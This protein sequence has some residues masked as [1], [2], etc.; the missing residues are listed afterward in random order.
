MGAGSGES[1]QR[2]TDRDLSM[3]VVVG[4]AL[5]LVVLLAAFP[6]VGLGLHPV[7]LVGALL[8]VMF[9]FLFVTVSS[10]LTG[11]IGS[12]SNP[13]SGMTVATLL[14]TCLI[15]LLIGQTDRP[16]MLLALTIA[17]VVCVASSN[18]GT[19]A[20]DLKTGYLVGATPKL[21]QYGILIGAFTSAL[22]LGATLYVL[23]QAGTHY[24][25]LPAHLPQYRIPDVSQL[26]QL[27]RPGRPHEDDEQ[28]Y[29]VLY[30]TEGQYPGVAP[31]KYLVDDTGTFRYVVDPAINGRFRYLD[32]DAER[33]A[34]ETTDEGRQT[35]MKSATV[36]P[37]YEAPKT[38]LMAFIIDGILNQKLPWSLV[39]IGVLAAVTMELAGVASLPFAVGIYLP[40]QTSF[41]IFLGGM[42][43]WLTDRWTARRGA[44][45]SDSSPG[46]LLSSGLIAG[47]ALAGVLAAFLRLAPDEWGWMDWLNLAP[48]LDAAGWEMTS[49]RWATVLAFSVLIVVLLRVAV[50][51][52]T[53]VDNQLRK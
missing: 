41:P 13:I 35:A 12:S 36:L 7:G 1:G 22:V 40:I 31:G 6:R 33:I 38:K 2:R 44:T 46:V 8:V 50:R 23:N 4:G 21:Q 3:G 19:T 30:A 29:R 39:L 11:E 51:R 16:A 5:L 45:D 53:A 28:T 14:L 34:A 26:T 42:T 15:F 27:E 37:K 43:R 24:T 52:P 17:A 49:S 47:G 10:R 20:Q 48:R 32:R 18:G 25:N 9:G